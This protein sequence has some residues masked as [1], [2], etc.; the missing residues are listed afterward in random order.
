VADARP[1]DLGLR[2]RLSAMMFI[3][4]AI[5]GS[6]VP[7][8]F[9]FLTEHRGLTHHQVGLLFVVG[10]FGAFFT[11][12]FFGQVADRWINAER[13][14]AVLHLA[15]AFV[16]W[17]LAR[18][19][20]FTTVAIT[21]VLYSMVST[22]TLPLTNALAFAH[23]PDRDRDF[24]KIRVWGPVGSIAAGISVGQWLL[25]R[26]TPIADTAAAVRAAQVA[27]MG[28]AFRLAGI[29]SVV[30]VIL[31][32]TILPVTPPRG[33]QKK[34]SPGQALQYF[35]RQPLRT[36][37]LIVFIVACM[38][39]FY[40]FHAAG[41]LSRL[42]HPWTPKINAVFGV[43]GIGLMALGHLSEIVVIALMPLL[44]K[45]LPRKT[46]LM[47]GLLAFI[48]RFG[49][50]AYWPS[51]VA[52]L[53][54]LLLQ[55]LCFGGLY[56]TGFMIVDEETSPETRA[57]AQGVFSIVAFGIAVLVGNYFAARMAQIAQ[58]NYTFLYAIPFAVCVACLVLLV[59][60]YPG[61]R[62]AAPAS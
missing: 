48:A 21:C 45:R 20:T 60:L 14:L 22:P 25:H 55:G 34:G 40:T 3:Q 27:G 5:W 10:S 53:P 24:G 42:Q 8:F 19:E 44:A 61:K 39:P 54:A 16:V 17:Q 47:I 46:L 50:F 32:L 12:F 36:L 28:D 9:P 4:Y 26:H 7:L 57:S 29:L 1:L 38:Q 35:G 23:L 6:W 62:P 31:A 30:L 13:L 49:V 41:F 18:V 33:S 37:L 11:T 51:P 52:V 15:A 56:F 59:A 2:A 58:G 43:G